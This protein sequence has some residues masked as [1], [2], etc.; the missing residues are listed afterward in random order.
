[1][2]T[3]LAYHFEIQYVC[4]FLILDYKRLEEFMQEMAKLKLE[5]FDL[6]RQNVV[7]IEFARDLASYHFS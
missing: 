4:S 5:K 2:I 3:K 7:R 1:M 6:L